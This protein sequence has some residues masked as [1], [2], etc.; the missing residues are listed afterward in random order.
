M[1]GIVVR[2]LLVVGAFVSTACFGDEFGDLSPVERDAGEAG[3]SIE[4]TGCELD[5]ATGNVTATVE[6][7]S[8]KEYEAILIDLE[9]VDAGGTVVATTSTSATNVQPGETYRLEMPLSPAGEL[10]E[11]F[12]C[13]AELNLATE[14]FG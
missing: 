1:R 12:T 10:G 8:D 2:A 3:I 5:D 7:T 6:V 9:L 14:P 4:V 11:G 13:E